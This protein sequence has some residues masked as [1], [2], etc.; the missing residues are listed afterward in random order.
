MERGLYLFLDEGA[1]KTGLL[2]M[3]F[4]YSDFS[5]S[6]HKKVQDYWDSSDKSAI[7]GDKQ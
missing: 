3:P 2:K 5:D 1:G 4:S 6:V 7:G